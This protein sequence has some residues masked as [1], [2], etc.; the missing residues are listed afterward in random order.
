MVKTRRVIAP[1]QLLLGLDAD[2][3]E[4]AA[5][6]TRSLLTQSPESL[7]IPE[8]G[9]A[10]RRARV[11]IAHITDH[12]AG[13]EI[14]GSRD[15]LDRLSHQEVAFSS[16]FE[17]MTLVAAEAHV[18]SAQAKVPGWWGLMTVGPDGLRDHPSSVSQSELGPARTGGASMA[19]RG[20]RRAASC[21]TQ[22][23]QDDTTK[24]GREDSRRHEPERDQP[25]GLFGI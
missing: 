3:I 8:L 6:L 2:P 24:D 17:R 7:V 10:T 14:K 25:R 22:S 5:E 16:T 11:D 20:C 4:I 9:L 13:Y 12:L 18:A 23:G 15:N 1:G 19:G 21:R